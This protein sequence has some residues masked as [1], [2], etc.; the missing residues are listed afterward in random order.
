[1]TQ[2]RQFGRVRRLA[3]GRWQARYPDRRGHDVPGPSTFAT[4]QEAQRFLTS[5]EAD[6]LRGTFIDPRGGRTTLAEWSTQWLDGDPAKR[7]STRARDRSVLRTHFLP[8]LGNR[9][10]GSITPPD[11]RR[12]VE[13][14]N[15]RLAPRTVRTNLAVPAAALN[16]AVEADLIGRSPVRGIKVASPH[17]EEVK[18]TLAPEDLVRLADAVPGRYRALILLAGMVGLRWSEAVGLNIGNVQFLNR[19][20]RVSQTMAEVE[21]KLSVE[22]T[23]SKSSVRT[24]SVPQPLLDELARHLATYRPGAGPEALVFTGAKGMPL[25]RSFAARVFK[26]AVTRAGLDPR[27]TFRGCGRWQRATWSTTESI[28]G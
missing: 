9:P 10:L 1:M 4:K 28:P 5:V 17:D 11:I 22:A 13:A 25:R 14:M 27:L 20:L 7:S 23:K 3:S 16:A 26:P 19:T 24:L 18:G 15:A 21:G 12:V 8:M 6:M 2:R